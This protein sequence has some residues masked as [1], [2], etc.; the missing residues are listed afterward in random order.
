MSTAP[1]ATEDRFFRST[2]PPVNASICELAPLT[3]PVN[4]VNEGQSR[5]EPALSARKIVRLRAPSLNP[6]ADC[7]MICPPVL[8]KK[9]PLLELTAPPARNTPLFE[10][11]ISPSGLSETPCVAVSTPPVI[12]TRSLVSS[13][14]I[15]STPAECVMARTALPPTLMTTLSVAPGRLGLLLQFAATPQFPSASGSQVTCP[16]ADWQVQRKATKATKAATPLRLKSSIAILLT[17]F[18]KAVSIE[19]WIVDE[20]SR[21]V[22]TPVYKIVIRENG[23][24]YTLPMRTRRIA[25]SAN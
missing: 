6:T 9:P 24:Y 3:F 20:Y 18:T 10:A 15:E 22:L 23:A 12:R 4:V 25:K 19:I 1:P 14:A 7:R 11:T 2:L 16:S 8:A 17:P 21:C 5:S 13:V